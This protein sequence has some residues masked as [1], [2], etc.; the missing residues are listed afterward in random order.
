MTH[1]LVKWI[2]E[3][4]WDVYPI[5]AIVDAQLGFRLM[6]EENYIDQV[7]GNIVAIKWIA[8]S[9]PAEAELLDFGVLKSMEKKRTQLVK[10][11]L[12]RRGDQ[13]LGLEMT[14]RKY[15]AGCDCECEASR[16]VILL[17]AQVQDLTEKLQAANDNLDSFA[18]LK[19][20]KKAS[21]KV[22][23]PDGGAQG[24]ASGAGRANGHR[25]RCACGKNCAQPP[26]CT[27]QWPA[28]KICPQF[29]AARLWGRGVAGQV[30]VRER[31]ELQQRWP[32]E[33]GP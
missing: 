2:T 4:S 14:K 23:E 17:E 5:R 9:P 30:P 28:H 24:H 26:P 31:F 33:K 12:Q 8:D 3:E 22:G 32:V 19:R 25:R 29:V 18:M 27:L 1:V 20:A 7:R 13:P 16:K 6:T 15:E 21:E 11:A 10:A